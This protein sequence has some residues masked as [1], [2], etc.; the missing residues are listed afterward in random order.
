MDIM[1][2]AAAGELS[3]VIGRGAI[4]LDRESKRLRVRRIW[5]RSTAT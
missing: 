2:R 4:E 1:R 3:E 5:P